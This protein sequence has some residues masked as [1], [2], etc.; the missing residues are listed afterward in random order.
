LA[1][2]TKENAMDE[3]YRMLGREHEADLER[4]AVKRRLATQ[5]R[6][7]RSAPASDVRPSR[8]RHL[9]AAASRFLARALGAVLVS[10]FAALAV[11]SGAAAASVTTVMTGLDNPRGLAFGPE[12]ALYVAEAGRGG[13][14]PCIVLRGAPQCYGATG[15]ITRLWRGEQERIAT[16]LPSYGS[17]LSATFTGPHDISFV[18]RGGAYVTIGLGLEGNPRSALDGLGEQFGWLVHVPASGGWT[19]IA[20]IAAHEFTTNPGGGLI[21]SNPYGLLAE[22]GSRVVADAGANA[23][24]RV[25]ANG[26]I[27]TLAVFPSR[28]QGRATDA[29]PT[30]VTIGPDGA[31]YVS[32]LTG[33][34]F[35]TGAA[36]IYRVVPGEPPTVAWSGFT[37]VIDIAFGPDG[38][39]YI[40]EHSTGPVFFALPGRL[41]KV[42][43]DGTRTTVVAGLTRPGSVA[44]GPD[45]A[46]YVSNHS[47]EIGI[48]EVLRIAP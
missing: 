33:V 34:P 29:V 44:V 26:E 15:A 1:T 31:Y 21:D 40:L 14:G 2:A 20:D 13:A 10:T 22:P 36:N 23:L 42:A 6:A 8:G 30:A 12:G 45:G 46:L 35:A 43:P 11:A 39:L 5:V 19:P 16:G 27:S 7:T 32:Q 9:G 48:G 38:S 24:L 41:L 37:T 17:A 4:E 28:A 47:T 3:T 25:A 18:G